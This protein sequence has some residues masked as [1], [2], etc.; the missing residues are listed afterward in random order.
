MGWTRTSA[1]ALVTLRTIILNQEAEAASSTSEWYIRI[2]IQETI[3]A[4]VQALGHRS[5]EVS[6]P[7]RDISISP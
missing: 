2:Y 1:D 5:V 4:R 6:C 3:R 7:D